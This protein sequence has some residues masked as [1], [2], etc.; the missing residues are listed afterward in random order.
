MNRLGYGCSALVG[1]RSRR[2]ARRLL[3]VAF[4]AGI[5]HFDVA[6]V[7]G[8]GDA[9]RILGEFAADK[10][11]VLTIASKFGIRSRLSHRRATPVKTAV[12]ALTRRSRRALRFVRRHARASVVAGAFTP[13]EM[14]AS[15][16][17]SLAALG[18]DRLDL[19]LL[20]DCTADEWLDPPLHAALADVAER[21]LVDRIG[22]AT[23]FDVT[24]EMFERNGTLPDVVQ[25]EDS[26]AAAHAA[27]FRARFGFSEIVTHGA[28]RHG[29]AALHGRLAA[30]D[31]LASRWQDR[32]G[33][34][35]RSEQELAALTLATLLD[36]NPDGVV[37]VSS[38]TEERIRANARVADEQPFARDQLD[39]FRRL[40]GGLETRT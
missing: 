40:V 28:F 22:T 13:S 27:T 2:E 18:V 39:E 37:L 23:S 24:C 12:R 30:D 36:A 6:R 8:S 5:R 35:V 10:R 21:G 17:Q 3:E 29:F 20:H 15:L 19:W 31:D 9:E 7:Y 14:Q 25:F 11:D 34:D 4:D 32:L 33:V 38:G 16:A 1:G 26:A